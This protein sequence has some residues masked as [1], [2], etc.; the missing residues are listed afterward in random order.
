MDPEH[1]NKTAIDTTKVNSDEAV[2]FSRVTVVATKWMLDFLFVSLCRSFKKA[3]LDE[4]NERL[5]I[6]KCKLFKLLV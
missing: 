6:F 5:S 3:E 4:F 2:S 1:N